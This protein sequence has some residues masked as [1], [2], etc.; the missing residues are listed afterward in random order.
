MGSDDAG[1]I[2]VDEVGYRCVVFRPE[3]ADGVAVLL[4]HLTGE[5]PAVNLAYLRWK[6]ERNPFVDEPLSVVALNG[7]EVVG[8]R[9]YF[10]TPWRVPG[11][12]G[13]FLILS[14][15]DTC[16]H[17]DHRRR[18]LSVA[19]AALARERFAGL[20]RIL[21]NTSCTKASL[22]GYLRMGFLPLASKRQLTRGGPLSLLAYL[23]RASRRFPFPGARI[24]L[25]RRGNILVAGEPRPADMAA[26]AAAKG[27][28]DGK[29]IPD[30]NENFFEWRFSNPLKK[31][32]FYYLLRND[33]PVG[34][35]ALGL[36]PNARRAY[37]IDWAPDDGAF[38]GSMVRFIIQ[39]GH[40]NLLSVL[41]ISLTKETARPL[42]AL[43]FKAD[44][45]AGH[46]ERLVK[47]DLPLL[48]RPVDEAPAS[49]DW[50]V[51]GLDIRDFG[52]W[53]IGGICA[54]D[55]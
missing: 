26:L 28:A 50:R 37:L 44:G 31:Y 47:G 8:F 53:A 35:L 33:A 18:G 1:M 25:G 19:L 23:L 21:L 32:L 36:S 2:K 20:G 51:E 15:G 45:L 3:M 43:G 49:A 29:F 40:F 30:R 48:V 54:D 27:S 13:P 16:V 42:S 41:D 46:L 22:P 52:N 11:R 55:A 17:P 6:Y 12:A 4:S 14:P 7:D 5:T 34:Y 10:A 38:I 39:E 24:P 9:G